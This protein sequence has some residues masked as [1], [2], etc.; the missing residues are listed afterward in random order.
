MLS[1]NLIRGLVECQ[2]IGYHTYEVGV[3]VFDAARWVWMGM[4][5]GFSSE[6][7]GRMPPIRWRPEQVTVVEVL[8]PAK[9]LWTGVGQLF[10]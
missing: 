5:R 9:W 10:L 7:Y 6:R 4:P 1:R 2:Q 8:R 3:W